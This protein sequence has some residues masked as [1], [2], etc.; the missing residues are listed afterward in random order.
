MQGWQHVVL[1]EKAGKQI[2]G[3]VS[4]EIFHYWLQS[5]WVSKRMR[6]CANMSKKWCWTLAT[7]I[8]T[9]GSL[10]PWLLPR[11][12][13][14]C[15]TVD[16][17]VCSTAYSFIG[18]NSPPNPHPHHRI[19]VILLLWVSCENK[20]SSGIIVKKSCVAHSRNLGRKFFCSVFGRNKNQTCRSLEL[21]LE[22]LDILETSWPGGRLSFWFYSFR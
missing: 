21:E 9:S 20:S 10:R 1:S 22:V 8:I 11:K 19:A 17:H 13:V 15:P 5:I 16:G 7:R 2:L 3:T 14:F 18:Q 4:K 12:H 6:W